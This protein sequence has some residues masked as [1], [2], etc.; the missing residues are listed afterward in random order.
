MPPEPLETTAP[1]TTCAAPRATVKHRAPDFARRAPLDEFPE[2]MD[3][4]CSRE[5]LRAYLR[6]LARV[7]RL[8]FGYRP[9]LHWL[10]TLRRTR[11]LAPGTAPVRILD[12]GC[13]YGDTP[14]RIELWARSN[15]IPLELTGLDLNPDAAAIAAE[16]S[17]SQSKIRYLA[18]D[19]F[20]YQPHEPPHLIVSS[21]FTH[22][23]PDADIVRFLCWMERNAQVGWFINDLSRHPTPYRL[24]GW[25]A[26]LLRLHPFVRHDGSVSIARAFVP[27]DWQRY[28][29][30][31][32]LSQTDVEMR[33]FTPGR[34]CVSRSKRA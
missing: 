9:I 15:H 33:G 12:V 11:V 4:P 34:L 30:A 13:G 27:A 7:N 28:C 2:R 23:L 17:P 22:H 18:A 5:D 3:E 25:F 6:D 19:V 1:D 31:A 32:G 10:E 20:S 29:A 26:R 21:L 24:F 8:L 16:A 14:R